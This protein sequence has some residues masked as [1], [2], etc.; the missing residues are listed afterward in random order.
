MS[1]QAK[2]IGA[3]ATSASSSIP[4]YHVYSEISWACTV[5]VPIGEMHLSGDEQAAKVRK[6]Y[7]ITKQ[8]ERW[9]EEEHKKFLEALKLYGRAWRRIEEHVGT[10]T[11]VQIRSHAQKFFSKVAR[12]SNNGGCSKAIEIPPP[13]PKR[14]PLHPYP[15]KS[16]NRSKLDVIIP[17]KDGSILPNLSGVGSSLMIPSLSEQGNRSPSPNSSGTGSSLLIS[18]LCEQGEGSPTSVLSAA[19]LEMASLDSNLEER[20]PSPASSASDSNPVAFRELEYEN[21]GPIDS[22]PSGLEHDSASDAPRLLASGLS[23]QE[24]PAMKSE[25]SLSNARNNPDQGV[26]NSECNKN[27]S[28]A[29]TS[30]LSLKLFGRTVFVTGSHRPSHKTEENDSSQKIPFTAAEIPSENQIHTPSEGASPSDVS[31][32]SFNASWKGG[33]NT[34]MPNVIYSNAMPYW[35]LY[36]ASPLPFI[37]MASEFKVQAK[38]VNCTAS[39]TCIEGLDDK[40]RAQKEGSWTG[41]NTGS[42]NEMC[43][44]DKN[45]DV[46]NSSEKHGLFFYGE[47]HSKERVESGSGICLKGGSNECLNT[48]QVSFRSC[49]KGFVPYRRQSWSEDDM[50]EGKRIRLCL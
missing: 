47:L 26:L 9:T 4:S 12:D 25:S 45:G 31:D 48:S 28:P 43:G 22:E 14:K 38:T 35:A 41:S 46:V 8:R 16:A 17:D 30:T 21:G 10:K 3:S 34:E 20:S 36:K 37:N 13:R 40:Q 18:S 44:G 19:R 27:E 29:E 49:G 1:V 6:P 23:H 33:L 32:P 7:T 50:R 24:K 42:A 2:S 15:R 11:A 5:K 39:D